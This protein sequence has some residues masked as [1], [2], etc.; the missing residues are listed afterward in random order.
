MRAARISFKGNSLQLFAHL[1]PVTI[2]K[3]RSLKPYLQ[4]LQTQ[5]IRYRWGFPFK[6]S[7]FQQGRQFHAS[8]LPDLRHHFQELQFDIPPSQR[9]SP[10]SSAR[11]DPHGLP[12]SPPRC[13]SMALKPFTLFKHNAFRMC[14]LDDGTDMIC[15]VCSGGFLRTPPP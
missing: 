2:A 7:F 10:S 5:V 15:L 8:T 13:P 6:L 1:S 3:R 4:V 12:A 9:E 11:P 14:L